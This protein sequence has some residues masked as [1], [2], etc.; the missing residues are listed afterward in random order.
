MKSTENFNWVQSG[1]R[2]M[3]DLWMYNFSRNIP[4]ILNGNSIQKLNNFHNN[5]TSNSKHNSKNSSIVIGGGPSIKEKNHL[6]KLADSDYRGSI[7]CTDRMLVPCLENGITPKKFPNFHVLTMD[8]YEIT[9]KF[10]N[11]KII[12]EYSDGISAIMSTCTIHET[13]E[14]CKNN[15]LEIY[16]FHPLIDDYRKI[17]S[18]NKLMNMMTKSDKNPKGYPGLQTGGNVGC[19]SWIFSWAILGCSPIGLI[20]LNMGYPGNTPLEKTQH[21]DQ[22]LNH[23]DGDETKVGQR[24]R[25]IFNKDLNEEAL[26]DPVFDFYREA[27][28]DLIVRTPQWVKTINATEGGSLFGNR[29]QNIKFSE[30][31]ESNLT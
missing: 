14:L 30:F 8:P 2:E 31:L 23:F 15:G 5:N 13:I 20:G 19:F 21:Y 11:H 17:S 3:L 4:D 22:I 26:L 16:W 28:L 25:K 7:V 18:I 1:T 27:F 9:V 6:Q 12:E 24:Y 10:Y 29:I